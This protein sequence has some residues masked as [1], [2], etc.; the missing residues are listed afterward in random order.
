MPLSCPGRTSPASESEGPLSGDLHHLA[1]LRVL[2]GHAGVVVQQVLGATRGGGLSS[3]GQEEDERPFETE[4]QQQSS[5]PISTTVE[6]GKEVVRLIG[7]KP[8]PGGR[9]RSFAPKHAGAWSLS[10]HTLP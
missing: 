6:Q 4:Q 1:I 8:R 5:P 7:G 2:E 9:H 3:S 10:P